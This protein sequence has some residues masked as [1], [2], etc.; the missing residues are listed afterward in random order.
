M[1]L[2]LYTLDDDSA[3]IKW[4]SIEMEWKEDL[5]VSF[6]KPFDLA[7]FLAATMTFMST[8]EKART[9]PDSCSQRYGAEE[10]GGHD[11]YQGSL[12][13]Q[14]ITVELT[15]CARTVGTKLKKRADASQGQS[16]AQTT[17]IGGHMSG[18]FIPTAERG[19][20]DLTNGH[21]AKWNEELLFQRFGSLGSSQTMLFLQTPSHFHLPGLSID[22]TFLIN[23]STMPHLKQRHARCPHL[24]HLHLH[25]ATIPPS[26]R[27]LPLLATHIMQ[28]SHRPPIPFPFW[29]HTL[30]N[31]PTVHPSPSPFGQ[32]HYATVH[33]SPSSFGHCATCRS[34]DQTRLAAE[35]CSAHFNK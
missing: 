21:I 26:T 19:S 8:V 24:I 18:R 25:Y 33:P 3:Q 27:P 35:G 13:T 5:Q 16:T 12:S 14:E 7:R 17:G 22:N 30:C 11:E 29:Q 1:F 4:T 20:I 23:L 2:Q 28:R 6:P 10:Q 31:G 32:T 34:Y 15:D 9:Q